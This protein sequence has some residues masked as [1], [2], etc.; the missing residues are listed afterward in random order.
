MQEL[1]TLYE[2]ILI[3]KDF[4][5]PFMSRYE[6]EKSIRDKIW[7]LKQIINKK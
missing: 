5:N 6:W 1:I 4:S 3:K 7:E 2:T